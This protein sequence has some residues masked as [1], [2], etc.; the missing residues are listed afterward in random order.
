[1]GLAIKICVISL[2]Q[3]PPMSNPFFDHPILNS[4]YS[5]PTQHWELDKDGQPTQ[6]TISSRRRAEFITP[7]PKPKKR[8]SAEAQQNFVFNEG[9]G[10]STKKQ[11]Y[12]PTPIINEVRKNLEFWKAI[13]KFLKATSS[14][15]ILISK[16]FLW[17]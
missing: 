3:P 10:L 8:K 11:Q 5:C 2:H 12:D 16:K 15:S 1:M 7:I 13:F 14:N 6:Q 17:V 4:P 9:M